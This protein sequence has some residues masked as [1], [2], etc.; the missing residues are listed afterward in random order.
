M[1]VWADDSVNSVFKIPEKEY[2]PPKTDSTKATAK[3]PGD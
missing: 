2:E 1:G 3:T